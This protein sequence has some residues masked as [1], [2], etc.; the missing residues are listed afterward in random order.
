MNEQMTRSPGMNGS[1]PRPTMDE[2]RRR[3]LAAARAKLAELRRAGRIGNDAA[4]TVEGE[5]R[6]IELRA[7]LGK[8]YPQ[9][10]PSSDENPR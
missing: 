2:L 3:A 1:R 5:L 6:R 10:R 9:R 4:E 7:F 8:L